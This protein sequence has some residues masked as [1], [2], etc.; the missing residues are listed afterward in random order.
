MLE[1]WK[2]R[3]NSSM[4]KAQREFGRGWN[5]IQVAS[6][7]EDGHPCNRTVVFRAWESEQD[8]LTFIT[9]R[10]SQKVKQLLGNPRCEVVWWFPR[11]NEQYRIKGRA[12]LT[13]DGC[14]DEELV[15][16]RVKAWKALSD[17]AREAFFM[18]DP[19]RAIAPE[20]AVEKHDMDVPVGGRGEDGKVLPPPD[21]FVHV[22]VWVHAVKYL[23]VYPV[24][25][26]QHD[27]LDPETG[28]W[29]MQR[30]TT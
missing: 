20:F 21:T 24:N 23:Q 25:Y 10:R 1:S 28:K 19:D 27:T 5:Y 14:D 11:T 3:I 22:Q 13:L 30:V 12:A 6:C 9:D 2:T 8:C 16:A 17:T 7:D 29:T 26:A 18:Q 15:K 4:S